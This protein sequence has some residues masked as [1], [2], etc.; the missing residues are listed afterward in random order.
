MVVNGDLDSAVVPLCEVSQR[1]RPFVAYI[2]KFFKKSQLPV[3]LLGVL[4]LLPDALRQAYLPCGR[5][6]SLRV[7]QKGLID[8]T[9][10]L[11]PRRK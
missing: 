9:L 4:F 6:L 10:E 5:C 3:F 1:L 2:I 7:R 11:L 8:T